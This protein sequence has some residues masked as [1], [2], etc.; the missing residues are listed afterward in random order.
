[1]VFKS[2]PLH[3]KNISLSESIDTVLRK[4]LYTK[5]NKKRESI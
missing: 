3:I 2:L 4:I 1:L 5:T